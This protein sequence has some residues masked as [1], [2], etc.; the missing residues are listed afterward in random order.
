MK[1]SDDAFHAVSKLAVGTGHL[2]AI[3]GVESAR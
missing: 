1:L 3:S 2:F